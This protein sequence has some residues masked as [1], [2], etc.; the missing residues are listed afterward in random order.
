MQIILKS[1]SMKCITVFHD[2]LNIELISLNA[3]S[4]GMLTLCMQRFRHKKANL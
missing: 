4:L 2:N 1:I 3:R